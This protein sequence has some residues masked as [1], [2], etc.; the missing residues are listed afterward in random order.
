[1]NT[2]SF[3]CEIIEHASIFT[4]K[5]TLRSN[6]FTIAE[7][8]FR[9]KSRL[10]QIAALERAL[11]KHFQAATGIVKNARLK[12]KNLANIKAREEQRHWTRMN[13]A[14][15]RRFELPAQLKQ[16]LPSWAV[17]AVQEHELSEI[18]IFLAMSDIQNS[19]LAYI[20][21]TLVQAHNQ[22]RGKK[23][24]A[25]DFDSRVSAARRALRAEWRAAA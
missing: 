15:N 18:D 3:Y 13:D 25:I 19:D 1:M 7:E 16:Q 2:F 14:W 12:Y 9:H 23:T 8:Y 21:E 5:C 6:N 10:R 11:E 24:W 22:T 4:E 17:N 20:S